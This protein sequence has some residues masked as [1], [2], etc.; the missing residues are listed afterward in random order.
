MVHLHLASI[1]VL[2]RAECVRV[3]RV[4]IEVLGFRWLGIRGVSITEMRV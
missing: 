3:V 4:V 1:T 2:V